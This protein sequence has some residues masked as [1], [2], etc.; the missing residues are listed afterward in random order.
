MK[1]MTLAASGF[2]KHTK[3]TRR[4]Q[5]LA[6]MEGVVPWAASCAL[7]E[8]VYRRGTTGRPPVGLQWMLRI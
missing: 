8:P 4:A 1:R 2:E 5:F 3:A 6:E 7:I